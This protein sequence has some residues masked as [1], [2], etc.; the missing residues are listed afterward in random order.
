[1]KRDNFTSGWYAGNDFLYFTAKNIASGWTA[2]F[3]NVL[4][5][6]LLFDCYF[7]RCFFWH[8]WWCSTYNISTLHMEILLSKIRRESCLREVRGEHDIISDSIWDWMSN[9]N[10]FYRVK[11]REEELLKKQEEKQKKMEEQAAMAEEKERILEAIRAKVRGPKKRV[12]WNHRVQFIVGPQLLRS[13]YD[14]TFW[15]VAV[16]TQ[17]SY[18]PLPTSFLNFKVSEMCIQL[19]C[20]IKCWPLR[21]HDG[22]NVLVT[23][24][25]AF[26]FFINLVGSLIIAS[27]WL[28]KFQFIYLLKKVLSC[29]TWISSSR[30]VKF[31]LF[32]C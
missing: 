5:S 2:E 18:T 27:Y 12:D 16:K 1:M 29:F 30:S 13:M 14:K 9:V 11:F 20:D 32:C 3:P 25:P 21:E 22:L 15:I 28:F 4:A 24:H 23:W 10:Y 17:K 7:I 8:T 26:F 19:L 31:I 6:C